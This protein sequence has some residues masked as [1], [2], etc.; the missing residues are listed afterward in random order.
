MKKHHFSLGILSIFVLTAACIR[1][2]IERPSNKLFDR[3]QTRDGIQFKLHR[4]NSDELSTS[5]QITFTTMYENPDERWMC[6]YYWPDRRWMSMVRTSATAQDVRFGIHFTNVNLDS[7]SLPFIFQKGQNITAKLSYCLGIKQYY[8]SSGKF[9]GSFNTYDGNTNDDV[10]ITL[11]SKSNNR[12]RGT[13]SGTMKH[14]YVSD[15][16]KVEDGFFDIAYIVR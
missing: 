8:D 12:L 15:S 9:M 13:F 2:E 3:V 10:K 14:S 11:L 6:G 7:L 1:K 5:Q 4:L 16:L